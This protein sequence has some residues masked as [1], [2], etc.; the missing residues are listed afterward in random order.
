MY[1]MKPTKRAISLVIDRLLSKCIGHEY[2]PGILR[3]GHDVKDL[4]KEQREVLKHCK[5]EDWN[6]R[7]E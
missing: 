1:K 3:P 5:S 4:S 6:R 2:G 7:I